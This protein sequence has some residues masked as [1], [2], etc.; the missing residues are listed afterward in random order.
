MSARPAAGGAS[1]RRRCYIQNWGRSPRD[2][3][4]C[5]RPEVPSEGDT[6]ARFERVG[7]ARR[8]PRS[9]PLSRQGPLFSSHA[10]SSQ[11]LAEYLSFTAP[12]HEPSRE[13][14]SALH[15]ASFARSRHP[16]PA[17]SASIST[18][19]G[20]GGHHDGECDDRR[21]ARFRHLPHDPRDDFQRVTETTWLDH[22]RTSAAR[23]KILVK[24]SPARRALRQPRERCATEA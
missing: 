15:S 14:T 16:G 4:W 5:R 19:H 6:S 8:S 21:R 12:M 10:R 20:W 13:S 7:E 3:Q 18:D 2:G 17:S 11:A 24:L 22:Y 23:L 1:H 9:F